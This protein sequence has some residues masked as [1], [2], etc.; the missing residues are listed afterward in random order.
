MIKGLIFDLDGTLIDSIKDIT[1]SVNL[2]L[3]EYGFEEVSLDFVRKNT[4]KG[5]RRL[6]Q[7]SLPLVKNEKLIDEITANYT[8]KYGEHYSDETDAYKGVKE[9][10][11]ILQDKGIKLSVNSNKKDIYTKNLMKKIFPNINFIAVYGEREGIEN[12]PDP[13]TANEIIKL[14]NLTKEEVLYVGDSE[15]DIKTAKNANLKS[16]GCKWGFRGEETLIKEGATY[17]I[18]KPQ[19]IIDIVERK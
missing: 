14:M 4:G 2:S 3:K 18:D 12:K 7:D 9:T 1:T 8:I 19:E 15:V 11:E 17:I 10:L 6:I 16:I 5:F 13:T